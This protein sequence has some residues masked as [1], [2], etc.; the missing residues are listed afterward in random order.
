MHSQDGTVKSEVLSDNF[1]TKSLKDAVDASIPGKDIETAAGA[2]TIPVKTASKAIDI[3]QMLNFLD[4]K[5]CL[6]GVTRF[7]IFAVRNVFVRQSI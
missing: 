6:T 1:L 7:A 3:T 2:D 5:H 4:G